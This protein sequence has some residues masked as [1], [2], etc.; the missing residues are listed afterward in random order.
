[1]GNT[2]LSFRTFFDVFEAVI[3]FPGRT[4]ADNDDEYEEDPVESVGMGTTDEEYV[5]PHF[6]SLMMLMTN[7]EV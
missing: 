6:N 3:E 2:I 1:M 7:D 5:I 4:D